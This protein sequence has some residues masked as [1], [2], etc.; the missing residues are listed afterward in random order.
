MAIGG[1]VSNPDAFGIDAIFPAFFLVLLAGELGDH[2]RRVVAGLAA[3]VTLLFMTF[4]PPG[5]PL[6][7]AALTSLW[8]LRRR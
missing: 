8:G 4:A 5:V 2:D 7:A 6:I 1:V 3:V